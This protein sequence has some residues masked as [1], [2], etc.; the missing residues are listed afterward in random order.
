MDTEIKIA[1]MATAKAV[2][3]K[4]LK[5]L[6]E[7]LPTGLYQIDTTVRV[8][9]TLKKGDPY[10]QRLAAKAD[11]WKLLGLAL[12]KLNAASIDAVVREALESTNEDLGPA[13]KVEV[14][15]AIRKVVA[16]TETTIA[17]RVTAQLAWELV[18]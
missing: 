9:G 5:P 13:I 2:S 12:N 16:D 14:D 7:S 18:G 3:D 11:P 10:T 4:E 15:R 6:S 17:G 8:Y 1:K